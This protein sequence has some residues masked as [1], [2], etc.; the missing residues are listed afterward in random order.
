M[1]QSY[2]KQNKIVYV[3]YHSPMADEKKGLKAEY[4]KDGVHPNLEGYKVMDDLV[5]KAISKALRTQ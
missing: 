1:L 2:A 4:S 3:D 5:E